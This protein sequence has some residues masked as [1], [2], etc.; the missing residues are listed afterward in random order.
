[1]KNTITPLRID[2]TKIAPSFV[3]ERLQ[4]LVHTASIHSGAL[5]AEAVYEDMKLFH[6]FLEE[7]NVTSNMF[8]TIAFMLLQFVVLLGKIFG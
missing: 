1:M 8:R 3:F 7:Q 2:M 5:D 4:Q 6:R